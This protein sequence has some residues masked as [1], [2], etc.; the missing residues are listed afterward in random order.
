MT[1]TSSTSSSYEWVTFSDPIDS[2]KLNLSKLKE[3][4]VFKEQIFLFDPK[5]LDIKEE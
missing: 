3:K 5:D 4:E 1:T 2:F